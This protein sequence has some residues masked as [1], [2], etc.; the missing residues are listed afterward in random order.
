[1]K[2]KLINITINLIIFLV[3][4]LII[5]H[6]LYPMFYNIPKIVALLFLGLILFISLIIK[7]KELRIDLIDKT[8]IA[9]FILIL[10]STIFSV[11]ISKAIIGEKN[12]YEGLLT[13]IVYFLTYYCAKNFYTYNKNIKYFAISTVSICSIIG[14]LQYYNIFPL[15]NIF[16]IPHN[17]GITCST[18]G[19]RN[20]FGSFLAIVVPLFI[21]LYLIKGKKIYLFVSYISFMAILLSMTR[22]AWIGI[23]IATL[24]GIIYIFKNFNKELLKRTVYIVLGYSLIMCFL[25]FPPEF[26]S[27][28]ISD[29]NSASLLD[30]RLELFNNEINI[31]LGNHEA[32]EQEKMRIGSGR[33]EIWRITLKLIAKTPLLGSGPDTLIDGLLHNLKYEIYNYMLTTGNHFDKAHN[34]YLQIAATIG[35]PALIIYLTFIVQIFAK[36]KNLFSNT[37]IFILIVPIISYISQAF[38]NISTIGVAPIFWF[39]LGVIQNEEFKKSIE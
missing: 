21:A 3:P 32:T 19:N 5:P 4:I 10:L 33:V 14:I 18:F 30:K 6:G 24:I 12:R 38:F 17:Y 1:M 28:R 39:L 22:S 13:F 35:I 36:S 16:N 11:N 20:F 2:N 31:I 37:A 15:Y 26:I 25:L 7:R 29:Y 9:F 23:A 8:L 34:E 27:S